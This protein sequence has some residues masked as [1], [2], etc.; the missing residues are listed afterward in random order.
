MRRVYFFITFLI[1][2]A[3]LLNIYYY[4]ITYKELTEFQ[5]EIIFKQVVICGQEIERTGSEFE[6]E[7]NYILFTDDLSKMFTDPAIK[8]SGTKKLEL[9]YSEYEDLI[10]N[11]NVYDNKKNVYSLYRNRKNQFIH[12]AYESQRQKPL[13][14]RE[15]LGEMEEEYCYC[16]PVFMDNK[17]QGNIMISIDFKNYFSS[18]FSKYNLDDDLWQTL[19][20][21]DGKKLLCN[22]SDDSIKY[23]G[24]DEILKKISLEEEGVQW[25]TARIYGEEARILSSY[26]PVMIM[27]KK[28]GILFSLNTDVILH[29]IVKKT[30]VFSGFTLLL[31]LCAIIIFLF[32]LQS[33]NK[34][35]DNIRRAEQKLHEII[36]H[37]PIGVLVLS[38]DKTID[39]INTSAMEMLFIEK[40]EEVI[41]K[42]LSEKFLMLDSLNPKESSAFDFS[43]FFYYER[44]GH[45]IVVYKRETPIIINGTSMSL[46]AFID[47]TPLEK[48]RR[49]E[50]ASNNA[51]SDFL[52]KMSHE[53]RTPMNGIIGMTD[54]LL[55]EKLSSE[56]KEH[57]E[58]IKK[59]ADLLL[60]IIDDILDF[61]KIEAGKMFLEEIPFKL[62]EEINFTTRLFKPLA[63]EKGIE[64]ETIIDPKVHDN[65]IGDPYRLRQI[66]SNLVG[67]AVK[68]THEGKIVVSV[69]LV[70]EY[71]RNITLQFNIEDT[72][73][74]IPKEKLTTIFSSFTQADGKTTRKYGGTG[75]GTTIA[76]QLVELMNGEIW[77]QSPSSI[78]T[79]SKYPGTTFS[80]TI[81]AYSNEQDVKSYDFSDVKHYNEV[82]ALI[83]RDE[84]DN[85]DLLTNLLKNFE[86]SAEMH[87]QHEQ[88]IKYV[89]QNNGK[90]HIIIVMDS[91]GFDAFELVEKLK[92]KKI[93]KDF[94]ILI[95]SS[96]DIQG[97]HIKC[98][99]VGGDYYLINP[100][101][102]SEIFDIIHDNFLN[103]QIEDD[104]ASRIFK[105]RDDISI[106]VAEDNLINQKVARTIFKNVGF[107]IDIAKNGFEVVD[108]MKKKHYDVIFM[109]IMMP[110]MDGYQAT[111]ELRSMGHKLPIIAMTANAN[112]SEKIKAF[113]YGIDD[114]ITKPVKIP[115]IKKIMIKWFAESRQK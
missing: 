17:V 26:Y 95:V 91:K 46:E 14:T 113:S 33:R 57:V 36:D 103:L 70:E 37:M 32:L 77:I 18:V 3:V 106:L 68:F 12:D 63:N 96:N 85:T 99:Q 71:E 98:K 52:A 42:N 107:D 90:Y 75:L 5:K 23:S 31:L 92:V 16:L 108:M 7:V 47:V 76:K 84:N 89:E 62:S 39:T 21:P 40:R 101:E 82:K 110:E 60:T 53:I 112:K 111:T 73:I 28:Y 19:I 24:M 15:K 64:L 11:I 20:T 38:Q 105:I 51:K 83:I 6:S 13:Q 54:S 49:Y 10:T 25:H 1:L 50:M 2:T 34:V 43:Y 88:T 79:S 74:G 81:E 100:I 78:S 114:Y 67:N 86:I 102:S 55:Q 94:L 97:N 69:E 66:I 61:S 4:S 22:H 35:I 45:E 8:E 115:T 104:K 58:I 30:L 41:G 93:S 29:I 80:F 9:F 44:E 59:S 56:Q 72:G 48:S 27:G 87:T 65:I 109:D